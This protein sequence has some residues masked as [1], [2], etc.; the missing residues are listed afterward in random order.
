MVCF[1]VCF[2]LINYDTLCTR[3]ARVPEKVEGSTLSKHLRVCGHEPF[4]ITS[5]TRGNFDDIFS[6]TD[7]GCS[8]LY[9]ALRRIR[10]KSMVLSV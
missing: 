10:L 1:P 8:V 3:W 4:C 2:V 5:I 7:V 6:S 9:C